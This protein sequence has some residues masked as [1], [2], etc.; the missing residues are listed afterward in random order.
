MAICTCSVISP[1]TKCDS[2]C[3][4]APNMLVSNS[5]TACDLSGEIDI[6]PIVTK[7]GSN[8]VY[9]SIISYKNVSDPTINSSEI[10]FK[11]VNNNYESG[12]IV[13]KVS[14][15]ILSDVGKIIIVYK[16]KCTGVICEPGYTCDKCTG[17]CNIVN[18]DL[19]AIKPDDTI[20]DNTSG[21]I[22]DPTA[23]IPDRCYNC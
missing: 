21:F 17:Q 8:P 23:I 9:Y 14:C 13:Y 1:P 11:P 22:L 18:T 2:N 7:C 4:Q 16:N 6:S 12:E 10:T 15:G 20:D 5:V 19:S 3:I